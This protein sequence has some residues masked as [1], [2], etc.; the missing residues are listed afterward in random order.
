MVRYCFDR[1][2]ERFGFG[3]FVIYSYACA[4]CGYEWEANQSMKDAPLTECPKCGAGK[5]K[6]QIELGAPFV[7]IGGGWASDGYS[8][9]QLK[10]D[11]GTN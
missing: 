4:E 3:E 1:R 11:N 6:R 9:K 8:K 2:I 5:A 10:V 7:L